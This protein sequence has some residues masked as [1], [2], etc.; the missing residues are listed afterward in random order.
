VAE[1]LLFRCKEVERLESLEPTE[2]GVPVSALKGCTTTSTSRLSDLSD[3]A[4]CA[5]SV[6]EVRA[7]APS[8]PVFVL[9]SP[10]M[11]PRALPARSGDESICSGD[12]RKKN[13]DWWLNTGWS[14]VGN[15]G[16]VTCLSVAV[17]VGRVVLTYCCASCEVGGLGLYCGI[18]SCGGKACNLCGSVNAV[19]AFGSSS[20]VALTRPGDRLG[21]AGRRLGV[22]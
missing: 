18:A 3:T 13:R 5:V 9:P 17:T 15:S 8:S 20:G 6:R 4:L 7:S 14:V 11:R 21:G 19:P 2:L 16:T 10:P 12:S 1:F 22:K